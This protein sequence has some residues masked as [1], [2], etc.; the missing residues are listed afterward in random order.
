MDGTTAD[1]AKN[2]P[3]GISLWVPVIWQ[4]TQWNQNRTQDFSFLFGNKD[5]DILKNF[6]TFLG[7]KT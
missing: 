7:G 5:M 4:L 3:N 1:L 6:Q 2:C